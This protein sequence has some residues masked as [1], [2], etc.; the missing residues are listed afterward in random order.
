[1]GVTKTRNAASKM[2][3][4]LQQERIRTILARINR[5]QQIIGELD[6]KHP[7]LRLRA[8]AKISGRTVRLG[9]PEIITI[10]VEDRTRTGLFARQIERPR[11][12]VTASWNATSVSSTQRR[13]FNLT[14]SRT[15]T[16]PY[17]GWFNDLSNKDRETLN[18]L[19]DNILEVAALKGLKVSRTIDPAQCAINKILNQIDGLREAIDTLDRTYSQLGLRAKARIDGNTVTF[20]EN[21]FVKLVL[22]ITYQSFTSWVA[23]D[24]IYE[25]RAT[26]SWYDTPIKRA[27]LR[28]ESFIFK[29]HMPVDDIGYCLRHASQNPILNMAGTILNA[30]EHVAKQNGLKLTPATP[31]GQ[32][33]V[34]QDK[35][36][37]GLK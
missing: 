24:D 17:K 8:N 13:E 3:V 32:A 16:A 23:G 33:G 5:I 10:E 22:K 20:G 31:A 2:S 34:A 35:K 19:E 14:G 7:E 15:S 4:D 30:A 36:H 6:Q 11:I 12:R 25:I 37:D 27:S 21:G 28:Q 1:M 9:D 29:S 18:K 26:V